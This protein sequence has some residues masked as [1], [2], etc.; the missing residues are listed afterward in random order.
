M[1]TVGLV[2]C[3]RSRLPWIHSVV[4][5]EQAPM[6]FCVCEE[7]APMDSVVCEGQ[8]LRVFEDLLSLFGARCNA[9]SADCGTVS[10]RVGRKLFDVTLDY[11]TCLVLI[12]SV[13]KLSLRNCFCCCWFC[14]FYFISFCFWGKK[15]ALGVIVKQVVGHACTVQIHSTCRYSLDSKLALAVEP[16]NLFAVCVCVWE[17]VFIWAG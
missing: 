14:L 11:F 9:G 5:E 6:D 12:C 15:E 16:L 7:Q 17:V 2:W 3:V 1:L 8:A 13:S 10:V 4:C